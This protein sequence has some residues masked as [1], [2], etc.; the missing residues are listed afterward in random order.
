MRAGGG[1]VGWHD[2]LHAAAALRF[3]AHAPCSSILHA[4]R[5]A[6]RSVLSPDVT[7][8]PPGP[9]RSIIRNIARHAHSQAIDADEMEIDQVCGRGG[10]TYNLMLAGPPTALF[11]A[12]H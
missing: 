3:T 11:C 9:P 4:S 8:A 5:A 1:G 7:P 10:K 6:L 2:M 12:H